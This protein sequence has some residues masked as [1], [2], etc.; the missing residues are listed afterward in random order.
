MRPASA[1][2]P[3]HL[4]VVLDLCPSEWYSSSLPLDGFLAQL[5]VFL[6][7]HIALE[8]DNSLAVFAALPHKRYSLFALS[9]VPTH[10]SPSVILY[11]SSDPPSLDSTV[12]PNCY[13]PFKRLDSAVTDRISAE[14][15][16]PSLDLA[17]P[18]ALVGALTRALCC[19][20]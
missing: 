9:V 11:A 14:L 17:A 13:P 10:Q 6:N 1:M 20:S 15:A 7:A 19:L 3:S 12:D 8:H 5:L 4:S 16:D 18:S 2:E